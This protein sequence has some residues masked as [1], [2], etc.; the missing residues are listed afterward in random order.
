MP[1]MTIP[2]KDSVGICAASLSFRNAFC[3]TSPASFEIAIK[4]ESQHRVR[5]LKTASVPP[6]DGRAG[7]RGEY[8]SPVG[9]G[10]M[11]HPRRS[12]AN[13]RGRPVRSSRPR[14]KQ[15]N[16]AQIGT[17]QTTQLGR[18]LGN[19]GRHVFHAT[20]LLVAERNRLEHRMLSTAAA[21]EA[22]S[23]IQL[24]SAARCRS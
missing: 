21:A 1:V 18:V 24:R 22:C 12:D 16:I 10:H 19:R 20:L 23:R 4:S 3:Q 15:Q 6:A 8:R 17:E 2:G 7:P 9:G 11:P 13:A 5:V 14:A